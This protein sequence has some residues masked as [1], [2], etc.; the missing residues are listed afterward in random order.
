MC[1]EAL[2]V[3][4]EHRAL[5]RFA[6]DKLGKARGVGHA[7]QVQRSG[8]RIADK[9][10]ASRGRASRNAGAD[11]LSEGVITLVGRRV[12]LARV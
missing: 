10:G 8:L 7:A 6:Q 11:S 3:E 5:A 12:G 2:G 9:T 4:S 1:G